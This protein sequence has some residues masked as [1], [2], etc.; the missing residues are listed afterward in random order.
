M[1][2]IFTTFIFLI[3]ANI[4]CSQNLNLKLLDQLTKVPFADIDDVMINGYGFETME[5]KKNRRKEYIKFYPDATDKSIFIAVLDMDDYPRNA[6]EITIA[7]GYS[8][9]KIKD[10]LVEDGYLYKGSNDIDLSVY[11][12]NEVHYLIANEPNDI[13]ATQILVLFEKN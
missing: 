10:D 6:L 3:F 8:L 4:I 11:Q 1:K 5:T 9:R 12:K 7:K 13:G 2:Q